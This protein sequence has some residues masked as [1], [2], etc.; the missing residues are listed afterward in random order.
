[1]TQ[2]DKVNIDIPYSVFFITTTIHIHTGIFLK[3]HSVFEKG[4]NAQNNV[5]LYILRFKFG[6]E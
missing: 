6:Y 3:Q 5:Y 2:T 1:M 4:Q